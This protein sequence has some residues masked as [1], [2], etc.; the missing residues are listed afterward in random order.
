MRNVTN[1]IIR[2]GAYECQ[3][4]IRFCD[5]DGG[6]QEAQLSQKDR[7]S[8]EVE[9]AATELYEKLHSKWHS[10]IQQ[11]NDLEGHFRLSE[12]VRLDGPYHV[13]LVVCI[14]NDSIIGVILWGTGSADPHF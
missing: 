11:A 7:V 3:I 9:S 1:S 14:N 10:M 4:R 8:F 6:V 13:F 12:M 5:S 2:L